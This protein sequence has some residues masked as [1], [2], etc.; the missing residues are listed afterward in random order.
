M[1][2]IAKLSA[3]LEA[4]TSRFDSR[5]RTSGQA[6]NGL[7]RQIGTAMQASGRSF[8]TFNSRAARTSTV[9]AN[10]KSDV[11]TFATV[12]ASAL[13]VQK[14]I[15][16]SDSWKQL[17][18]RLSIVT[19]DTKQMAQAQEQLFNIAQNNSSPVADT[20][21]AY[22]R[23]S[24]SLTDAE[25]KQYDLIGITDLLG[26]TLKIS[27]TNAA[28]AATFLQQFGQAASSDFKAIG[29]ELQTFADQNPVFYKIIRDEAKKSGKT[30]KEFAAD[31]GLSFK[32]VADAL[33]QASGQIEADA[34][35]IQLT[36]S[37]ALTKLDNAFLKFVGNNDAIK[38]GTSSLAA[39]ISELA[40]NFDTLAKIVG[41]VAAIALT[42]YLLSVG[43]AIR[44]NQGVAISAAAEAAA[45]NAASAS[46][47]NSTRVM[48]AN[49][50]ASTAVAASMTRITG[51]A[52]TVSA[53]MIAQ[54]TLIG[55]VTAAATL[56]GRTLFAAVGGAAGIAV[57]GAY[58]MMTTRGNEV[59]KAQDKINES[60]AEF[61]TAASKYSMA[62]EESRRQIEAD[63]AARIAAYGK[64]LEALN[65]LFQAYQK[66]SFAG[67]FLQNLGA[68][69]GI[70]KGYK[71][72]V[73]E[74]A[75]TEDAIIQMKELQEQFEDV[76]NGGTTAGTGTGV[77]D[78][79]AKK[80]KGVMDALRTESR[81]LVL[82]NDLYGR[83]QS[84]IDREIKYMQIRDQ[85]AADGI[86]LTQAQR[87]E[88]EK[89]LG[90]IEQQT[91]RM[92]AQQEQTARLKE[93]SDELGNSLKDAFKD[94]IVNGEDFGDVL[95]NLARK[96]GDIFLDATLFDPLEKAFK[97]SG[98]GKGFFDGFFGDLLGMPSFAVGT[99]YVPKDMVAK[100][101]KGERIL[102]ADENAA[103]MAGGGGNST[104]NVQIINNTPSKVNTSK[105]SN[106]DLRVMIDEAVAD[107][108]ATP[109]SKTNQALSQFSQRTTIR[110]N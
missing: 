78:A 3:D 9:I 32:F 44:A 77:S 20:V 10:L 89:Y 64:E 90:V 49:A 37:Q 35:K 34:G 59:A 82:Q 13:S 86:Q 41:G 102:T 97:G 46:F 99:P 105:D 61:Q 17:S 73:A 70:G 79:Q 11:S 42:R 98:S 6:V 104:M 30:L 40:D 47:A 66:K 4:N 36:V 53:T 8:D 1:P 12:A 106:G 74:G 51:A 101:H 94:A 14:I 91:E 81:E 21:D 27:G 58:A 85:L 33:R 71:D 96:I 67:R 19:D 45:I 103:L 38:S 23:L 95:D 52:A 84:L 43:L 109:G 110:R 24:N 55:R 65:L 83:K 62:S 72:I 31:G 76:R 88:I 107:R 68:E 63:V 18:S 15:Q 25:K 57:I 60:M 100:I 5:L 75:A 29:Q 93:Y 54:A 50:A 108:I 7:Q 56:L 26:K 22:V 39:A 16:Y 69:V 28:G 92:K 48:V 80:L 87:N 2:V